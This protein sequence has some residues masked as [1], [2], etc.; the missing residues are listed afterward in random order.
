[1]EPLRQQ[2]SWGWA[3]CICI[4][5]WTRDFG[6]EGCT[7]RIKGDAFG[8]V[9]VIALFLEIGLQGAQVS[10]KLST[11]SKRTFHWDCRPRYHALYLWCC[12]F[13]R[14]LLCV[15][16]KHSTNQAIPSPWWLILTINLSR[17]INT[18]EFNEGGLCCVCEGICRQEHQTND[19]SIPIDC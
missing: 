18:S 11:K 8:L 15:L 6:A 1:M 9:R 17:L 12:K 2:G 19:S 13:N 5:R 3:E 10:F 14:E 4:M 16:G 7:V